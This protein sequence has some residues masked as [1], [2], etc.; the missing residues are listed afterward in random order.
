MR[1]LLAIFLTLCILG[2]GKTPGPAVVEE[3]VTPDTEN[4]REKDPPGRGKP[5]SHWVALLRTG[6]GQ[7]QREA[8][9]ELVAIGQPAA[10]PTIELLK[11]SDETVRLRAQRA[12]ISI[13]I[14][15]VPDLVSALADEKT[16]EPAAVILVK[17]GGDAV[18]AVKDAL[19]HKEVKV[20]LLACRVLRD[21]GEPARDAARPLGKCLQDED[22]GVRNA[23]AAALAKTGAGESVVPALS[24]ALKDAKNKDLRANAARALGAVGTKAAPAIADLV[25]R[26]SKDDVADVRAA[27]AGALGNVVEPENVPKG[28]IPNLRVG[29]GDAKSIVRTASARSLGTL[30][31]QPKGVVP[32]LIAA[33][34]T[35][36]DA[37]ARA[38]MAWAL[39]QFADKAESGIPALAEALKDSDARVRQAALGALDKIGDPAQPTLAKAVRSPHEDVRKAALAALVKSGSEAAEDAVPA[40]ADSL[41]AE[42]PRVREEAIVILGKLGGRAKAAVPALGEALQDQ[43]STVRLRAAETLGKIGKPAVATLTKGL[44]NESDEVRGL[45]ALG[46]AEA[47]SA[48]Q[49]AAPALADVI[50]D[51]NA[52]LETRKRA[53]FALCKVGPGAKL[54]AQPLIDALQV[55]DDELRKHLSAALGQMGEPAVP[56]LVA[57]LKDL[58][59]NVRFPV[60]EALKRIGKPAV[61]A[62]I[63]AVQNG[64]SNAI[65]TGAIATLGE[66]G[67]DAKDAIPALTKASQEEDRGISQ[68]AKDALKKITAPPKKS[69]PITKE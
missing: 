59:P 40:L 26:L 58:N 5:V 27:A 52:T 30:K 42:D 61:P 44:Q 64:K 10:G 65:R 21:I 14:A 2:C 11:D 15:S 20:R 48:G 19:E 13:G 68:P 25:D 34:G 53:A 46:L 32:D 67:P 51:K 18:T 12:L 4:P 3:E 50:T 47:G 66:I 7:D 33:I 56:P 9:A 17:L 37:Q 69:G 63:D 62:L 60:R 49:S 39:G 22:A 35:E 28:V 41:K 31:A 23:A 29:L 45:A 55:K 8:L 43:D 54:P 36:K 24:D 57:A 38:A 16:G 1:K 6:D